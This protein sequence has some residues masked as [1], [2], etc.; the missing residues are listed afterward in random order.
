M[1][2][3]VSIQTPYIVRLP[4]MHHMIKIFVLLLE[5]DWLSIRKERCT[6]Y[7]YFVERVFILNWHHASGNALNQSNY[8]N[9]QR[10]KREKNKCLEKRDMGPGPLKTFCCKLICIDYTVGPKSKMSYK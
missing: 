6:L 9:C 4:A 2:V 10:K 3:H 8:S 5:L 1:K 7:M